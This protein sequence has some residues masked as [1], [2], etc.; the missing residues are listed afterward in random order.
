MSGIVGFVQFAGRPANS[1]LIERLTESLSYRGP[2][3][4]RI[5]IGGN[6]GLGCA[7]LVTDSERRLGEIPCTLD[8]KVWLTAD[9]RLDDR[10]N[11]IAKI[12]QHLTPTPAFEVIND[13]C[14]DAE[15][16]LYAYHTWGKDCVKHLIGDFAF[17][18]WDSRSNHLFCARDHLGVR[19]FYYAFNKEFFIFSNSLNSLRLHPSVSNKLNELAVGDFLLFGQNEDLTSTIFADIHRLPQAQT[20]TLSASGLRLQEYWTPSVESSNHQ[21]AR[22]YIEEFHDLLKEAV[23]DRLHTSSVGISMSGG[24]DS[25]SVAAI[26]SQSRKTISR[27]LDLR[28]Y[29]VV[30]DRAF[31]DEERKYAEFTANALGIPVEFLEGDAINQGASPWSL[32]FAPEPF[33]VDPIYIVS[34]EILTRI[35]SRSRVALTGW[36]GDTF[37]EESP[38]HLFSWLLKQGQPGALTSS[39]ARYVF[40]EHKPPPIG[41]R[42]SWRQWRNPG[43]NDAPFPNWINPTFSK[44][45]ALVE[46]WRTINAASTKKAHP[47]RPRAFRS[48]FSAN[49]AALFNRYDAGVTQLPLEVRHPLID[50][51]VV[52]Y[53]LALPVIPWLIDKRILR[54]AMIKQLPEAVRL[55]S[56]SPLASDPGLQ[57]SYSDKFRDV[58]SFQPSEAVLC[59][60]NRPAIARVSGETDRNQL[61]TNLRPFS[62]N[63]WLENSLTM[64]TSNEQRFE[65]A[66]KH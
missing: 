25:S 22:D 53:L 31:P 10:R 14:S 33:N 57:L 47:I 21:S 29:C 34:H 42:T 17:A 30:Y 50:I 24:L 13:S 18:I 51:R 44:K 55:R 7:I 5:W 46:R 49:W 35:S 27:P 61:W 16:L 52:E 43:W 28:G 8:G 32:G 56:K 66:Q 2:D 4:Q 11:L 59:F 63:L 39:L 64:E 58:D 41:L 1:N 65:Y 23:A 26:A 36:D 3:S 62:L 19:Q 37:M 60:I 15:L 20:L 54:E 48:V 9:L 12:K 38:R 6:V 40:F 45:L